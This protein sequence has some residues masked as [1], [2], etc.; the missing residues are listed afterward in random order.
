MACGQHHLTKLVQK[1]SILQYR[2]SPHL[3]LPVSYLHQHRFQDLLSNNTDVSLCNPDDTQHMGL[4]CHFAAWL[5]SHVWEYFPALVISETI[6]KL[7]H[8]NKSEPRMSSGSGEESW[9]CCPTF[10][11]PGADG[12]CLMVQREEVTGT[13]FWHGAQ[14]LLLVLQTV[15]EQA[16]SQ[17]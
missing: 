7:F 5:I 6:Q 4:S 15:R 1:F 13:E 12:W 9:S 8:L 16:E 11:S 14:S 17:Q 3:H 10:P 2:P